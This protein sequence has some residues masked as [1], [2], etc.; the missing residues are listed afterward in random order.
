MGNLITI[1][2]FGPDHCLQM[3]NGATTVLLSVLLLGGSDSAVSVWEQQLMTWLA[4]HDQEVFGAGVVGFD[5]DE[6]AWDMESFA[7]QQRFVLDVIDLALQRH[8]WDELSYDP[9]AVAAQ[10]RALRT[11]V[12]GYRP[13]SDAP[14]VAWSWRTPPEHL[15]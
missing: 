9:P 5:L 4:E 14:A 8:R 3:S 6:I 7:D 11:L 10:L 2:R 15:V 13:D 12:A 1:D